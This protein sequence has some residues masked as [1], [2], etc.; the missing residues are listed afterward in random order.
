MQSGD[1]L[2]TNVAEYKE[3]MEIARRAFDTIS[4]EMRGLASL[5]KAMGASGEEEENY[6][7]LVRS[8]TGGL[9]QG[10]ES[11]E[12]IVERRDL[13]QIARLGR[14]YDGYMKRF[15]EEMKREAEE[16]FSRMTRVGLTALA[17]VASAGLGAYLAPLTG[18]S[19]LAGGA[20]AGSA[21][22]AGFSAA[23]YLRS[24]SEKRSENA[25]IEAERWDQAARERADRAEENYRAWI[26]QTKKEAGYATTNVAGGSS[27]V[28][29]L[30]NLLNTGETRK[31][32]ERIDSWLFGGE[33]G[34]VE[35]K[36]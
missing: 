21:L 28:V 18:G 11:Y 12:Q 27:E 29:R 15:G 19:A 13:D 22:G 1:P 10:N 23:E 25:R 26:E 30:E 20:A 32:V 5:A 35:G 6:R 34:I 8:K 16:T 24:E 31:V 9:L 4:R 17:T 3:R 33:G 2:Y 14:E 36:V 7:R